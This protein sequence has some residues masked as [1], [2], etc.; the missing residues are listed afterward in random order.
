[1]NL[2]FTIYLF[3]CLIE[4]AFVLATNTQYKTINKCELRLENV[5]RWSS[6]YLMLMSVYNA[7]E[8]NMFDDKNLCP[9]KLDDLEIYLQILKPAYILSNSFNTIIHP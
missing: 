1:M 8:K 2:A 7:S 9:I 4:K 3:I 6:S 5:T